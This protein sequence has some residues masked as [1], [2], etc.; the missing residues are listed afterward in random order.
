MSVTGRGINGESGFLGGG[1]D[2]PPSL[3]L[4]I[5]LAALFHR[6]AA[7]TPTSSMNC[8]TTRAMED[9]GVRFSSRIGG[10]M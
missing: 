7:G 2:C 3:N 6:M 8:W 4:H 9:G 10:G 1:A 5:R